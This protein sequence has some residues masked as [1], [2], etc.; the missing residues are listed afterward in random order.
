VSG[1][2]TPDPANGAI[3]SMTITGNVTI[4]AFGGTPQAGQ[5][6][7][8]IITQDATGN[9]LLTSTM[10]FAGAY[11]TLSTAASAK[12]IVSVFYDGTTYFASLTK[13]YS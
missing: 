11:K 8:L 12:D 2:Q 13:A 7:T 9:R 10:K 1:A 5:S 6:V 3:Q 4:S